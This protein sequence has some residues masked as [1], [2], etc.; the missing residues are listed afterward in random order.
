M[1]EE[2]WSQAHNEVQHDPTSLAAWLHDMLHLQAGDLADAEP[3]YDKAGR[4][5]RSGGTLGEELARFE[6]ELQD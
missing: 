2:Q 3:W 6:M 1:R 4:S 5:F